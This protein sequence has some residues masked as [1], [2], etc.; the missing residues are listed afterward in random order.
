MILQLG[1]LD[2]KEFT[3]LWTARRSFS[4]TSSQL[5]GSLMSTW[6]LRL[7]WIVWFLGLENAVLVALPKVKPCFASTS[8][9]SSCNS[10]IKIKWHDAV[11]RW[12]HNTT[13]LQLIQSHL[14]VTPF[15]GQVVIKCGNHNT[16]TSLSQNKSLQHYQQCFLVSERERKKHKQYCAYM[17][18]NLYISY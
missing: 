4:I 9:K 2:G 17:Y 13:W 16:C 10:Q 11:P 7:T 18:I 3:Q 14:Q 6:L 5:A 15:F 1:H 8:K 12:Y